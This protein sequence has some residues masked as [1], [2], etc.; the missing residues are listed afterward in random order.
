M[1]S[2]LY[3]STPADGLPVPQNPQIHLFRPSHPGS[4]PQMDCQDQEYFSG[5]GR[6]LSQLVGFI[7]RQ[8]Y[9]MVDMS[10]SI[11]APVSVPVYLVALRNLLLHSL[12]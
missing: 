2:L 3:E 12:V 11:L 6:S 8:C 1:V 7:T 4:I 5:T 10:P 9:M